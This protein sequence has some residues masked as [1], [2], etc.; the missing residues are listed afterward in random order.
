MAKLQVLDHQIVLTDKGVHKCTVCG[1][2]WMS[3]ITGQCPGAPVYRWD[4][5]PDGMFTRKQ[6]NAKNLVPGPLAGVI[7]Y[8][9]SADGDGWL[10]VYRESEATQKPALSPAQQAAVGRMQA[11]KE[12]GRHC[13]HCGNI[14]EYQERGQKLC[15]R[16]LAAREALDL[17]AAGDFVIWDSET[18][19]LN[20]RFVEIAVVDPL[21]RTLFDHRI[22]PDELC[23]VGAYEVHGIRDEEL[24]TEPTFYELY[25]ELRAVLH[26]QR[27]VVYNIE[28]D[29]RILDYEREV[30]EY[31]HWFAQHPIRPKARVCAMELYAQYYGY[32]RGR[33][34]GYTW[35]KLG[36]AYAATGVGI[37]PQSAHSALGDCLRTLE[38]LHG[39]ADWYIQK[40]EQDE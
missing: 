27:W 12:A 7:R 23:S 19:D 9:K 21:G 25:D 28:F 15:D 29:E 18:T 6:L 37:V 8:D 35:Q 13:R 30:S 17:V 2:F 32:W 16:C 14:L 40:G 39:M 5:W 3:N 34:R 4:E 31:R 26:D 20:G 22:R 10:R 1:Q 38:V 11:A 33:G 36:A 24:A